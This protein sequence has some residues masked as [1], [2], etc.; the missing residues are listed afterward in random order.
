LS[1]KF[2]YLFFDFRDEPDPRSK[3]LRVVYYHFSSHGLIKLS[4]D[5][6]SAENEFC[7]LKSKEE[8]TAV[9]KEVKKKGNNNTDGRDNFMQQP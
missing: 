9:E 1:A 2:V 3:I 6:F 7:P 4:L 5:H 8:G